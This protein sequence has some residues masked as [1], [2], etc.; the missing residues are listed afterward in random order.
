MLNNLAS[1]ALANSHSTWEKD[2][3]M[4]SLVLCS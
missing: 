2:L 3:V 1:L 4:L